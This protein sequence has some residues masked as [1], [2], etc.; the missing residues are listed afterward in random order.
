MASIVPVLRRHFRFTKAEVENVLIM[1]LAFSF[2]LGFDDGRD[3]FNAALWIANFLGC[4]VIASLSVL[5]HVCSQK[6]F[7]ILNGIRT[8]QQLSWYGI[9]VGL[10]IAFVTRGAVQVY[11]PGSFKAYP[12]ST[13]RIG[14]FRHGLNPATIGGVALMGPVANVVAAMFSKFLLFQVFGIE[15]VWLDRFIMFNFLFALYS[16]LPLPGQ[17]GLLVFFGSRLWYSFGFGTLLGYVILFEL[18]ILSLFGALAIGAI[19]W[20]V[21]Y[22]FFERKVW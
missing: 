4:L 9:G 13:G 2:I 1:I 7:G 10:I 14:R 16:M 12:I 20:M 11:L 8:E 3:T 17:T 22:V 6:A 18:G 15:W 21:Y 5:I 19:V